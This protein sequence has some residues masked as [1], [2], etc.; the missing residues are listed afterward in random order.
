MRVFFILND[1]NEKELNDPQVQ[2]MFKQ[3]THHHLPFFQSVEITINYHRTMRI[4][5]NTFHIFQPN[6]FR[7]VQ[8]LYQ[9]KTFKDMTLKKFS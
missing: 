9:H 3:P 5:G 6:N 4:N 1:L 7:G 8:N 2:A